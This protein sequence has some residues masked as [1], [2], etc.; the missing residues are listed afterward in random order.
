MIKWKEERLTD[1][2]TVWTLFSD[3]QIQNIMPKVKEHTLIHKEDG[4]VGSKYRQKYEEGKRVETYTVHVLGY[5][6][7][8]E[9][10]YLKLGFVLAKMFDITFSF[11]LIKAGESQT[12]FI[13][14]GRNKGVN[15]AGRTLLKLGGEKNNKKVV[16]DFM[17]TVEAEALKSAGQ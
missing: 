3:E 2:E 9:G 4:V 8:A 1:I 13:Y 17:D 7:T 12:V 10:K 16:D 14:E 6:E 11:T 15:F 5:E